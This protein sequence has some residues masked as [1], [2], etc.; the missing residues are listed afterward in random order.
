LEA[1]AP[2]D[3][4]FATEGGE[5]VKRQKFV[6]N[7]VSISE[8][9]HANKDEWKVIARAGH[10]RAAELLGNDPEKAE[11]LQ[12]SIA[13][14]ERLTKDLPIKTLGGVLGQIDTVLEPMQSNRAMQRAFCGEE[15]F[16]FDNALDNGEVVI[17][18]VDLGR[19]A[20]SARLVYL[21]GFE[22]LRRWMLKRI[23]RLQYGDRLTPVAFIADEYA[24]IACKQHKDVWRLCRE[25]QI[26]PVLAFQ[27]M[28]DLRAVVGGRDE[29]D[30]LVA[31][32]RQKILFRTDDAAS[33]DLISGALGKA[34]VLREHTSESTSESEGSSSGNQGGGGSHK[35]TSTQTQ[36]S[37]NIVER[38]VVDAQLI[39]SLQSHIRRGVPIEDQWAEAIYL[40]EDSHGRRIA[41][42]VKVYAWD[43]PRSHAPAATAP[44]PARPDEDASTDDYGREISA[45]LRDEIARAYPQANVN[46]TYDSG[47]FNAN[48]QGC[49]AGDCAD[50]A[51][52]VKV[53]LIEQ[54]PELASVPLTVTVTP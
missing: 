15:E 26:A 34:E 40:G 8:L 24:S 17:L 13:G 3:V 19:Y 22:Q 38:G 39:Q 41:D 1:A 31:G 10:A 23:Q 46:V 45:A 21:L 47:A 50:F 42:V 5:V 36:K 9:V 43:P 49:A 35:G 11:D 12:R 14:F 27:L 48:L 7:F 53:W 54:C 30:G 51:R 37:L 20:A 2:L 32:F 6:Y 52:S 44:A 16:A 4:V 33:L 29:A 28:S 25:A 18:D